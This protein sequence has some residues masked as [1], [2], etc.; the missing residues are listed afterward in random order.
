MK[1]IYKY[2][3][4]EFRT[5]IKLA[6]N[7]EVLSVQLQNQSAK[8]WI[9]TESDPDPEEMVTREFIIFGTGQDFLGLNNLKFIS[10]FQIGYF[11]YHLF[12][13]LNYEK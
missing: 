1:T 11:V 3:L 12:E 13:N 9:M 5:I 2:D 7:S 8:M 4:N 6:K 10:T